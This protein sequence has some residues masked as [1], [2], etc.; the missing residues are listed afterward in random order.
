MFNTI[1]QLIS[2]LLKY[3]PDPLSLNRFSFIKTPVGY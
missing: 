2:K 1:D 3:L